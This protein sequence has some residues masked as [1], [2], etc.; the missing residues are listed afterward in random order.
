MSERR[1]E[2]VS[3]NRS[4]HPS[5]GA[6]IARHSGR[7]VVIMFA[8]SSSSMTLVQAFDREPIEPAPSILNESTAPANTPSAAVAV[9]KIRPERVALRGG[10]RL[11]VR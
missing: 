5:A 1:G 9:P 3:P 8:R 6:T 10:L 7:I 4:P 2:M 11:V